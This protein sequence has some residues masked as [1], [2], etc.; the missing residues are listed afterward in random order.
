MTRATIP[1][2]HVP[3]KN[4]GTSN[5]SGI[6]ASES[7]FKGFSLPINSKRAACALVVLGKNDRIWITLRNSHKRLN[8]TSFMH[9][10]SSAN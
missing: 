3:C 8:N 1:Y 4:L 6:A 9:K 7:L 10:A 2:A 5:S